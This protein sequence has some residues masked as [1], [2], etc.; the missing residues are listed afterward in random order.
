MGV[1][2]IVFFLN[3]GRMVR[4]KSRASGRVILLAWATS[5]AQAALAAERKGN[6]SFTTRLLG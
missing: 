1:S 4:T 3:F 2:R 6:F 5:F